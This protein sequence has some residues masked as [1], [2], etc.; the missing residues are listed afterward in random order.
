[1]MWPLVIFIDCLH[2]YLYQTSTHPLTH[3]TVLA[4]VAWC[5]AR[6]VIKHR[7]TVWLTK[8]A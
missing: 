2:L 5:S 7:P 6:D 8:C 1:M 3:F 4:V